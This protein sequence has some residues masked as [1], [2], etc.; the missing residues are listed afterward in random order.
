V[1]LG[2]QKSLSE[3]LSGNLAENVRLKRLEKVSLSEYRWMLR[4]LNL[5]GLVLDSICTNFLAH[6]GFAK[7]LS[8]PIDML[9]VSAN[10][11]ASFNLW[12]GK[13]KLIGIRAQI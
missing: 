9:E 7:T 11:Y 1:T 3:G 2:K 13:K 6:Q 4:I 8:I 10:S 5:N 12:P